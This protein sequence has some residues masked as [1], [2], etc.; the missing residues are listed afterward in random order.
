MKTFLTQITALLVAGGVALH[1]SALSLRIEPTELYAQ[2]QTDPDAFVIVDSRS[3]DD[4][5]MEHLPGAVSLPVELTYSNI[6]VSG[7]AASP[8]VMQDLFRQIGLSKSKPIIVYGDGKVVDASRVFWLMEVYGFENVKILNGGI[9]RWKEEQLPT[10]D[11]S[12]RVEASDYVVTI[13][14]R[15]LA[16]KFATQLAIVNPNQIII[17]ARP[18]KAYRGETSS[19]QRFGHIPSALNFNF[20][21]SLQERDTYSFLLDNE[22]IQTLFESVGR[23]KKIIAYCE[24]GRASSVTYLTLREL[25]YDVANYDASWREWGN[26]LSLPIETPGGN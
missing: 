26:D 6:A 14:R 7:Q 18:E 11:E 1:A 2:V 13:D 16:T 20:Q 3:T 9:P 22:S 15:R 12:V 10:S 25:G 23:D 19:A 24:V 21:R 5:A 8:E 17:D 4:Y